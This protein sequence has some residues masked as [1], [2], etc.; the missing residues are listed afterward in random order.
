MDEISN[1]DY[2]INNKNI[3]SSNEPKEDIT[4]YLNQ[5]KKED[6][7]KFIQN[8]NSNKEIKQFFKIDNNTKNSNKNS[9][10]TTNT[11]IK[12]NT[13][14]IETTNYSTDNNID[15]KPKRI[16]DYNI[17]KN[18]AF[19]FMYMGKNYDG[20]VTQL[21]TTNTIENFIFKALV[22]ATL[23]KNIED[24]NYSRCGRT[25]A[26]VSAIGNVFN[27]T[28][29]YKDNLDYQYI[30]NKILPRDIRIIG[31][32]E[33]DETFDSRF[34]CLYRE[35]KYYFVK[36][37]MNIDK[38]KEGVKKLKGTHNY[39][40]FCKIDKSDKS[41][42]EK[43]FERRIYEFKVE[44]VDNEFMNLE[45]KTNEKTNEN[46]IFNDYFEIYV[47]TIKGSAFLW[48]QVRCM[49]SILFLI[50]QNKEELS[51]IDKLFDVDNV[52]NKIGYEIASDFPLVRAD[53]QFENIDFGSTVQNSSN[54]YYDFKVK[55]KTFN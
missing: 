53:C 37:N 51:I 49:M 55:Y 33:V 7:I 39:K 22:K 18:F 42:K 25:D 9:N 17:V 54:L 26:G 34:S 36:N 52:E 23:V 43:N 3:N 48:H 14:K 44:K 20:L 6:L 21:H 13:S 47:A 45:H 46:G 28:L 2:N 31:Q 29:R 50:G 1:G 19:K 5:L 27:A 40:N 11:E 38:I 16:I 12:S 15:L 32:S 30:L 35:Y 24:C 41:E 8:K 4:A 10:T